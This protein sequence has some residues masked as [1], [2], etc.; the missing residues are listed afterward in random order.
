MTT[1]INQDA[2][3]LLA[4]VPQEYVFW[5][6]DGRTMRNMQELAEALNTMA[7][8]VFAYHAN[9]QKND[10]STWVRDIIRDD[11]LADDLL[12]VSSRTAAA[13]VVTQRASSLAE[14]L[15]PAKKSPRQK[16]YP[17]ASRKRKS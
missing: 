11:R 10:F 12:Q 13:I 7:D 5:C 1:L 3:K 9:E 2:K 16:P 8:D 14:S 6:C 4:D 15:K 17:G